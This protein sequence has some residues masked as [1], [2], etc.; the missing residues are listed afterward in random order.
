MEYDSIY[1]YLFDTDWK[2]IEDI[3][4]I[5]WLIIV[6]LI[7][8]PSGKYCMHYQNRES[9]STI[10]KKKNNNNNNNK[11]KTEMRE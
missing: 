10:Y 2:L 11:K 3:W 5:Y 6:Y 8:H 4:L 7:P 9:S 1:Y